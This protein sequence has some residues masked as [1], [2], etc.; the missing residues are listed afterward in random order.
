MRQNLSAITNGFTNGGL[1]N[2]ELAQFVLEKM[3]SEGYCLIP[4]FIPNRVSILESSNAFIQFINKIGKPISHD[5]NNSIIWDISPNKTFNDG[6]VTYSEHS[7][8]ADLH[9]D[10]QYSQYPEEYFG[11][12]TLKKANC[13]GGESFLLS[14]NDI[15]KELRALPNGLQIENV[16]KSSQYPFIVP[17]VF[18]QTQDEKEY[19]FGPILGLNEIRFRVDTLEKAL[20]EKPDACTE[21]QIQAYYQLKD[22]IINSP[23]IERFFLNDGDLLLV[24]NKTMLH[25]RSQFSDP[26]RHLLRI[27]FNSRKTIE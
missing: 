14:L 3:N 8:E 17:N 18:K 7:H 11:L 19:N 4:N 15:L 22:I 27:R 2:K 20:T 26:N 24:N 6:I 10:S 25:G 9:T 16:L 21:E 13:G 23:S 5:S 12:L 1:D